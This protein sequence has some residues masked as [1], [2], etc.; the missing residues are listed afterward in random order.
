MKIERV[1]EL[2]HAEPFRPFQIHTAD[3]GRVMVH[4]MDYVAL[5][6]SGREMI[7]YQSNDTHQIVDLMMVTRLEVGAKN[8][9]KKKH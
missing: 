8:G 2:L 7:V 1:R 9:L 5:Q 6:P 4:H 3:G